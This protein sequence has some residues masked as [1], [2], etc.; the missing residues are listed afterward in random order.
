MM[1]SY[2]RSLIGKRSF[3]KNVMLIVLPIIVQNLVSNFVSLL[4]NVMVGR[5]GTDEISG[6]TIINQLIFVFQLAI[7]GGLSG[8]GIFTAQYFGAEDMEGVRYTFRFKLYTALAVLAVTFGILLILPDQLIGLYLTAGDPES[9]AATL[10][11]AKS[12]LNI[13]LMGLPAFAVTQC[14]AH[15]LREC[16]QTAMPMKASV[17]EVLTNMVLNYLLI[18]GKLGLPRL[19]VEGAAIATVI[20]H[21]VGLAILV[22]YSHRHTDRHPF[23]KGLYRSPYIPG[24]VAKSIF[25]RGSVLLFNEVLWSVSITTLTQLYTHRGLIVVAALSITATVSNIFNVLAFSMGDAI[26]IMVGQ[27]L[28]ASRMEEARSDARQLTALSFAIAVVLLGVMALVARYIPLI[29]NVAEE[30][31]SLAIRLIMICAYVMPID[32]LAHCSYFI[33]R[34]GGKTFITFLYD[35]AFNWLIQLPLCYVL[36]T[37]TEMPFVT[38]F[39]L[40]SLTSLIKAVAGIIMVRKGIWI[41]N[42]IEE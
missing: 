18:Y 11:Y 23:V 35:S 5:L 14:Y 12:Y 29:Y 10:S 1:V 33:M 36:V 27:D 15:T 26:S 8:A 16:G 7:F 25:R 24:D 41:H 22:I 2:F 4:D 37:Y 28:G 40:C 34:A 21:L 32:A 19:G 9:V 20:S 3:Y 30:A 13:I 42:I 38:I 17:A 39:L 6:V 31:R